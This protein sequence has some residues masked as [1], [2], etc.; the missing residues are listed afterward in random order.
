VQFTQQALRADPRVHQAITNLKRQTVEIEGAFEHASDA[1]IAKDLTT[2]IADRGYR[3]SVGNTHRIQWDEFVIAIPI[4]IGFLFLYILMQQLGLVHLVGEGRASLSTAFVIGMIASLS[5]CMAVVGGLVLSLSASF[6][7]GGDRIRPQLLFHLGRLGSFFLLG[8]L[9]GVL[10]SAFQLNVVG[11]MLIGIL[12]GC[13]MLV[14]GVNLLDVF[15]WVKQLQ[16]AMPKF[17]SERAERITK[18]NHTLTPLLAGIATFF[19]PCG[20]TQSMQLFTLS[21]G[22][23]FAGAT[24]MLVFALGTFPVLALMSFSSLSI[25]SGKRSGVFYKSAGLVV[26][27]FGLLNILN[28]FVAIGWIE[29]IFNF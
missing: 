12:V 7:K 13:V 29:P 6:A 19:L 2:L 27:L 26:I 1:E 11:T 21:T 5:T 16:P 4:V 22:D 9:I 14:L 3:L 10:G 28:S 17:L 23:F 15:P 8:G 25:G 24:T 20:F 18:L